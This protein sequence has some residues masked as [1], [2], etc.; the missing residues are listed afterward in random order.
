MSNDD[1]LQDAIIDFNRMYLLLAKRLICENRENGARLFGLSEE[2]TSQI[3]KLTPEQIEALSTSD[4]LVC[5]LR[6]DDP[7]ILSGVMH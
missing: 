3:G 1:K 2:M 5:G 6:T 4:K 7:A